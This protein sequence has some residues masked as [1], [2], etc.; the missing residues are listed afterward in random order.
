MNTF[1]TNKTM[2]HRAVAMTA[3]I[4]VLTAASIRLQ[5]TTGTCGNGTTTIPFTDVSPDSIFFCAIAEAFLSGLTNG[6]SDTTYSP[7]APVP[8]EQMAAFV[9]RT[10]D[11][12]LKR[13]N[14]RAALQNYWIS[15]N[16]NSFGISQFG[17]PGDSLRLLAAD[18]ADIWVANPSS[19]TVHRV[20]ASDGRDVEVWT[21]APQAFG[22][23]AVN[24]I[25]YVTGKTTPGRLYRIFALGDP[26]N[27]SE[28]ANDL[29]GNP[30]ALTFDGNFVWTAN[31]SGSISKVDPKVGAS[32][33]TF[34]SAFGTPHGILFDGSA[35]WVTDSLDNKLKRVNANGSVTA[36]VDTGN[37]P[38]Y[39]VFDGM[40][41][42][43]PNFGSNSVTVVRVKDAEGNPLE[44]PLALA[45]LTGNGLANP[46]SAAF[47]GERVLVVNNVAGSSFSL[48]KATDLRPLGG[49]SIG[50]SSQQAFG[51]CSDG[52]H[53]WITLTSAAA[54][55]QLVRL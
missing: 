45:T 30:E 48:W 31:V 25:V 53:F 50:I 9:T 35:I 17:D 39:P 18:G 36:T 23:L 27:V 7:S 22:V 51:V 5:A 37:D 8:R 16:Q 6:T 4:A 32:A 43:V 15:T 44:E 26:G 10:L 21:N 29:G 40:N 54:L 2:V 24:G 38:R 41:I 3:S 55:S 14:R 1:F 12:S 52:L 11:Q 49:R 13:G 42:W 34:S 19:D 46:L 47:D 33:T 20:R 28:L